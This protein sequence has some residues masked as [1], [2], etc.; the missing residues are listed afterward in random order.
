LIV[1]ALFALPLHGQTIAP[2]PLQLAH[3]QGEAAPPLVLTLQDALERARKFDLNVQSSIADAATARE[4]R[5]QA[6]QSLLPTI[7]NSTQY[8]GT[9]GNGVLPTGRFVT[10]D[11]VHVYREWGVLH[12]EFNANTFLKTNVRRAEAA[13]AVALAKVEVAQ[14]GLV[15]T[16]TR[17]YYTL[18]ANQR[19]YATAQMALQGAQ[20]FLDLTQRQEQ[21]GQVAHADVVKAQVQYEQQKAAFQ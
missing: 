9:Q 15:V 17:N 4:D 3:P 13:Q 20:R 11:G 10:N 21:A 19:K 18:T 12:E 1:C 8:L 7:T 14:R 6:K 5:A 16:V 2:Q